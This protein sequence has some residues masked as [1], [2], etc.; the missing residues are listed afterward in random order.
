MSPSGLSLASAAN[1]LSP[2]RSSTGDG[3][4]RP[5]P[6]WIA[7]DTEQKELRGNRTDIGGAVDQGLA[8]VVD[9]FRGCES[10]TA[11]TSVTA[12]LGTNSTSNRSST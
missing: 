7:V 3:E 9:I 8:G 10:A 5:R 11:E 2:A 6:A 1:G 12:S 4:H